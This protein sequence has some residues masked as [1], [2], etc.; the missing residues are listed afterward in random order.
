[1]LRIK[2]EI[3]RA[4]F[5]RRRYSPKD[6]PLHHM[7][8]VGLDVD[9]HSIMNNL[10][11]GCCFLGAYI[12]LR[13]IIIKKKADRLLR[14]ALACVVDKT[15]ALLALQNMLREFTNPNTLLQGEGRGENG[16]SK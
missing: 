3:E 2:L 6:L 4:L 13:A 1:M 5:Q 8:T 14:V 16:F 7:Y 15:S 10:A 9:T 12:S 11:L